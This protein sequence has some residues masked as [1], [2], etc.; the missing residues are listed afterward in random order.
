MANGN[1]LPLRL[2]STGWEIALSLCECNFPAGFRGQRPRGCL[3]QA[4][5]V[6]QQ[7]LG[8]LR[9]FPYSG[10]TEFYRF[11]QNVPSPLTSRLFF[12]SQARRG[13]GGEDAFI[14]VRA[15]LICF[16]PSHG[17]IN[18][19]ATVWSYQPQATRGDAGRGAFKGSQQKPCSWRC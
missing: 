8:S 5:R 19:P 12:V 1:P 11:S 17:F 3:H 10:T 18:S 6:Q 2:I 7:S 13:K 16:S 4:Q 14:F 9:Y 15:L